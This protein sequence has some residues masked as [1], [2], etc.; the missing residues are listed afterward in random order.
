MRGNF[1]RLLLLPLLLGVCAAA[2]ADMEES[3]GTF[4]K[5]PSGGM[6][7]KHG[8][9]G[10]SFPQ[11]LGSCRLV[12]QFA[13]K[14]GGGVFIRYESPGDLARGD[15]FFFPRTKSTLSREDIKAAINNELETVVAQF[16]KMADA[17]RYKNVVV[18]QP[19]DGEIPLWPAGSLPL[20]VRSLVATKIADTLEGKKEAQVKQWTG[21][22]MLKGNII[23]IRYMHP[24]ATGEKGEAALKAFAGMI[25]QI[26]KDPQLRAQ[27]RD[28]VQ[29]YL[30][31]PFSA[32]GQQAATAVL[33]YIQKTPF[34]N[35]PIPVDALA[36]WLDQFKRL[37]PGSEIQLL[38]AFAMG[39]A[40]AGLND[41]E[42]EVALTSGA[43]QFLEI[44][45]RFI[46]QNPLLR[47]AGIDDL[48]SAVEHND[49]AAFLKRR[50][51]GGR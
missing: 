34:V 27:M 41:A 20:S 23:T 36:P 4:A 19:A 44:Y 39:S 8:G 9:T 33:A 50:A 7:W 32:D 10:L 37:A 17:G 15:V 6:P 30:A 43:R 46:H 29:I 51:M 13:F 47:I 48:K 42:T 3:Q 21:V 16:R 24:T 26:I 1:R 38:R 45:G 18:D 25:F 31:D 11:Q 5:P 40:Q 2:D 28:F 49:V 35:V 14:E 22:T 12:A